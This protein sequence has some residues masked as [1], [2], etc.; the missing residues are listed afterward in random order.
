MSKTTWSVRAKNKT[1]RAT[2]PKPAPIE[3]SQT[4]A[5]AKASRALVLVGNLRA[6]A[7]ELIRAELR[8][9][10][11]RVLCILPMIRPEGSLGR[12]LR[13]ARIRWKG[14]RK[15]GAR[16]ISTAVIRGRSADHR[17]V[18]LRDSDDRHGGHRRVHRES[19][20]RHRNAGALH[21]DSR[22][23]DDLREADCSSGQYCRKGHAHPMRRQI[24]RA[25]RYER[26]QGRLVRAAPTLHP[27][28]QAPVWPE[29]RR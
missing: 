15:G 9:E 16:R 13:A 23:E 28:A 26:P 4:V 18:H 12:I 20:V 19:R 22:S 5:Q 8:R 29:R 7:A 24:L 6:S 2:A 14:P 27:A 25:R 10:P 11:K 1:V 3:R 17:R 21:D